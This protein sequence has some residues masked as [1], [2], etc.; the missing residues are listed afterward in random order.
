V[1][2]PFEIVWK[3][4]THRHMWYALEGVSKIEIGV[5]MELCEV[6]LH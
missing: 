5:E 6:S 3:M 1:K 4:L 2:K